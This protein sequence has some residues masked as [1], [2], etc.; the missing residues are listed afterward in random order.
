MSFKLYTWYIDLA[1][2]VHKI[3]V[4]N[5]RKCPFSILEGEAILPTLQYCIVIDIFTPQTS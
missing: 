2:V 1:N 3:F 4:K 5:F